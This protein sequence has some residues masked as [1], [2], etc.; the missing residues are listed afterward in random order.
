MPTLDIIFFMVVDIFNSS[1][2]FV[3][4][5]FFGLLPVTLFVSAPPLPVFRKCPKVPSSR[6]DGLY[7]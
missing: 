5:R 3:L 2:S 1:H 7:E 6:V 4:K